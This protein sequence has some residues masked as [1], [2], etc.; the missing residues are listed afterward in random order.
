MDER[1]G[2]DPSV[3]RD[4][5]G[6]AE[7]LRR[8]A[9]KK[10]QTDGG[11]PLALTVDLLAIF[12]AGMANASAHEAKELAAFEARLRAWNLS[13]PLLHFQAVDLS[14]ALHGFRSLVREIELLRDRRRSVQ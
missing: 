3:W 10:G 13:R 9:A 1:S 12:L 7:H 5:M 8:I 6:A 14:L 11:V 2:E 4:L